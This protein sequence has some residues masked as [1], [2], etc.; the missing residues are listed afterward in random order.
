ME[1][2]YKFI[3]GCVAALF[4]LFAPI[5][6]LIICTLLFIAIDFISGILADRKMAR[7]E[8]RQWFFESGRA[9][10]TIL[11]AGLAIVAL[12]MSWLI[13][14]CILQF[15]HLNLAQLF[16]GFTCG[17][18]LWSFLENAAQLSDAPLFRWLRQFVHR[19]IRK[20][21]AHE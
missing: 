17:I 6:P 3:S 9:W 1:I 15:L 13:D 12:G 16:A 2:T 10:H 14:S 5:A 18:E 19:R 21:V 7:N 4:A 20:E 11:K 8:G